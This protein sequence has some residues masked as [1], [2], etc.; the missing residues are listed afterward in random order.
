MA[1][2]QKQEKAH[3]TYSASGSERWLNCPGSIKLS[4]KF[5]ELPDSKYSLEGTEAH[6][7]F[8]FL[9]KNRENLSSAMKIAYKKYPKE[10]VEH[11]SDAVAWVLEQARLAEIRS[12]EEPEILCE[13]QVDSS[14][15]TTEGQF[16][17]LDAAVV[18][19]FGRL[20]VV[21]YKYGAGIVVDPEGE[22][23]CG[24]PQLVYY[25]LGVAAQYDFMFEEVELTV[26]QP[27]AFHPS[28]ETIR[29][30]KMPIEDLEAWIPVFQK[31]VRRTMKDKPKLK[32]GSWCKYCPA[33]V[34]CP[35]LK[36]ESFKSAQ[37]AF[38]D[39]KGLR[40]SPEPRMIPGENLGTMLEAAEKIE[41]WISKLREHALHLLQQG[42]KVPGWKLVE[43]RATRKW[44]SL[45]ITM[46]EATRDFGRKAFHPPE[47]LSPN[48]LGEALKKENPKSKKKI[49]EWIESRVS[50]ES[51]GNTMARDTDR[52]PEVTGRGAAQVFTVID[53]TEKQKR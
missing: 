33:G 3:A 26:I 18:E 39:T 11:G 40:A 53:V 28:G 19:H 45:E 48:Q 14:S 6:S 16:G 35:E 7:C 41:E 47:L 31:G 43:K 52:R 24:N 37:L 25:A 12:G 38:S 23:E 42:K 34:G 22:E 50:R 13:T 2:V 46:A 21:D 10:M 44:T 17:T 29:T 15:Y 1:K 30:F 8:E 20:V 32:A 51:S 27:R 4:E 49:D 5:P 36:D 9:L